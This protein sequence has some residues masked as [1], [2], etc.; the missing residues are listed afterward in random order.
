LSAAQAHAEESWDPDVAP[1]LPVAEARMTDSTENFEQVRDRLVQIIVS[2]PGAIEARFLLA[3]IE[4]RRGNLNGAV[5]IYRAVLENYPELDRVR[6]EL[7]ATLAAAGNDADAEQEY[8]RVLRNVPPGTVSA[9]IRNALAA[10]EDRKSFLWDFGISLAGDSNIN[11]APR[12]R[13]VTIF[14]LPFVLSEE[15]RVQSGMGV[16]VTAAGEWRPKLSDEIRLRLG[17]NLFDVDYQGGRFDNQGAD[18]R[19]GLQLTKERWSV[20]LLGLGSAHYYGGALYSSSYGGRIENTWLASERMAVHGDSDVQYVSVP[21]FHGVNGIQWSVGVS[22]V[23]AF[24]PNV[25]GWLNLGYGAR[26]AR[27]KV[28]SYGSERLGIGGRI[29]TNWGVTLT[30]EADAIRY[31][32]GAPNPFFGTT[33]SDLLKRASIAA[34]FPRFAVLGLTP[35]LSV[36]YDNNSSSFVASR[37]ERTNFE[38]SFSRRF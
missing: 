21:A 8:F 25:S 37:Y 29:D 7:A 19:A 35:T 1:P 33:E 38:F 3:E 27:V 6:L 30:A 15:S 36:S 2:D 28:F 22:P 23:Y 18:G 14:G 9:R 16:R 26:D 24:R 13:N 32:Y 11:A 10:I 12:D 20:S 4:R 34:A 17:G 31:N 5:A